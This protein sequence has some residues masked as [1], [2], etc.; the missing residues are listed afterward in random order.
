MGP[1]FRLIYRQARD[2]NEEVIEIDM[3]DEVEDVNQL[4]GARLRSQ[5]VPPVF[6]GDAFNCPHCSAFA[7]Q[8]WTKLFDGKEFV[9]ELETA[10]CHRCLKYSVWWGVTLIYPATN[11]V[12]FPSNDLPSE[13]RHDY[14]E[15]AQIVQIS[16]RAAAALLRLAI[17][18][19][20]IFLGGSGENLNQDIA[21]LVK[22]GLP[23]DVQKMLDTVRVIGN[24]S[25]HPGQINLNEE[26]ETAMTLFR[27]VNLIAERMI[28]GPNEIKAVYDSLPLKDR[29]KI[30]KRDKQA[31]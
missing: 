2:V 25:V 30:T 19:F 3:N 7:H 14:E 9:R 17:Q 1:K 13:V 16:P 6:H 4:F 21:T 23:E 27:L 12:E 24:H 29:E 31:E 26:P 10:R 20:C 5:H 11:P 15:A 22:D 8:V 18:Q 28:T